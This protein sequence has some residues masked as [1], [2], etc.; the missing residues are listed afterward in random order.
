MTREYRAAPQQ[1]SAKQKR[2]TA[3]LSVL[4]G[5]AHLFKAGAFEKLGAMAVRAFEEHVRSDDDV[6]AVLGE[7]TRAIAAEVRRRVAEKLETHPLE[8]VRIDFED[9]YGARS[10]QD[11]DSDATRVGEVIAKGEASAPRWLGIRVRAFDRATGE[12]AAHTLLRVVAGLGPKNECRLPRGF[13]VTLPKVQSAQDVHAFVELCS[14]IEADRGLPLRSIGLELMIE[15][16]AA[17]VSR[18]GAL[19]VPELLDAGDGRVTSLHLGAYDLLSSCDVGAA[20]QSLDHPLCAT[21]RSLMMLAANGRARI[22]DGAT[23][24]LPLP[25]HRGEGLTVEQREENHTAILGAFREHASAVDA[26][27]RTGIHQG[28]DLHPAQLVARYLAVTAYYLGSLDASATRLRR[29]VEQAARATALGQTFDDA[30]TAEGLLAFFARGL[31]SGI[32]RERDLAS[33]GLSLEDIRGGDFGAILA[34]RGPS[35]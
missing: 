18:T 16:P 17:L 3:P 10:H 32:L 8:D 27:L 21:A 22:V 9:G 13:V 23:T 5:G 30:A 6:C 26:A 15:A 20:A 35:T 34:S 12:R 25:V 24:R 33:T 11:E 19:A 7:P 29:F 2:P 14:L 31:S 1:G 28:W 4:Y